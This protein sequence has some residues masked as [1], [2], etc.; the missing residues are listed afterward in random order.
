MTVQKVK[1]P[2]GE[3]PYKDLPQVVETYADGLGQT[4]FNGRSAHI[5]L[6]VKR[7]APPHPPRPL[8]GDRVTAAR[9]VLDADAVVDLYNELYRMMHTL[10]QHG[11]IRLSEGIAQ[12]PS[13]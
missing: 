2:F 7:Y 12:R 6:T 3:L 11:L 10:E 13:H 4:N 1:A 9:L 5:T 8:T